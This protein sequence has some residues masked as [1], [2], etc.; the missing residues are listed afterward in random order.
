MAAATR[1]EKHEA[2]RLQKEVEKTLEG[3]INRAPRC[4][5]AR[6][7]NWL[8]NLEGFLILTIWK[9]PSLCCRHGVRALA[10]KQVSCSTELVL[11]HWLS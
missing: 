4:Q 8:R 10:L 9:R 1:E 11:G 2:L 6:L 3:Q 7:N 5:E